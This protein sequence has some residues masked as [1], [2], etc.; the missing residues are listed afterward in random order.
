M[1][2]LAIYLLPPVLT[3]F[4]AL[5]IAIARWLLDVKRIV[6]GVDGKLTI[7]N[8]SITEHLTEH[9][10]RGGHNDQLAWLR[11]RTGEPLEGNGKARGRREK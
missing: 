4:T 7:L 2:D 8:G 3:L 5:L 9:T 11:G 6:D 1:A 10:R